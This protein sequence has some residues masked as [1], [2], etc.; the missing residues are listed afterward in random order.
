M[1]PASVTGN[2]RPSWVVLAILCCLGVF[3]WSCPDIFAAGPVLK[4]VSLGFNRMA[5]VDRWTPALVVIDNPGPSTT[6]EVVAYAEQ[7]RPRV[8]YRRSVAVPARATMRVQ[9]IIRPPAC[10]GISFELRQGDAILAKHTEEPWFLPDC[11]PLVLVYATGERSFG[12]PQW[13]AVS[14]GTRRIRLVNCEPEMMP[15]R[16]AGYDAVD[17]VIVGGMSRHDLTASQQHALLR[18]L[19][20]GGLLILAPTDDVS[21][22]GRSFLG[23]FAPVEIIERRMLDDLSPLTRA[24]GP[25]LPTTARVPCWEARAMGGEVLLSTGDLALVTAVREGTGSVVFVAFDLSDESLRGWTHLPDFYWHLLELRHPWTSLR[26]SELP[27]RAPELLAGMV[28]GRAI[29]HSLVGV[30]LVANVALV[31]VAWVVARRW[32]RPESGWL[33]MVVAAPLVALLVYFVAGRFSGVAEARAGVI[34]IAQ[35]RAGHSE[36]RADCFLGLITPDGANCTL[37]VKGDA[38]AFPAAA[39]RGRTVAAA[40]VEQVPVIEYV[41][42]DIK[43]LRSLHLLP[44]W[45]MPLETMRIEPQMGVVEGEAVPT[46][47]GIE[48][49]VR[50]ASPRYIRSP[51]VMCNRNAVAMP[52]LKPGEEARTLLT[53]S[54]AV[55]LP[56]RFS[57]TLIR[58]EREVRRAR[59]VQS[60]FAR[61]YEDLRDT[62]VRFF[63]WVEHPLLGATAVQGLGAAPALRSEVL[64]VVQ[65]P[66]SA[67][68]GHVLLPKGVAWAVPET[69]PVT[70]FHRGEWTSFTGDLSLV[71]SFRLPVPVRAIEPE[72]LSVFVATGGTKPD[73]N[74]KLWNIRREGWETVELR[75]GAARLPDPRNYYL[76]AT[77][78]VRLRLEARPAL[79]EDGLSLRG[80]A[81]WLED[82][83]IELEGRMP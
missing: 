40:D 54:S 10:E 55:P 79:A 41:D 28:G 49:R 45:L 39:A 66:W 23:A 61:P 32:G 3:L 25:G 37:G 44:R 7:A 82:L 46:P 83:D 62:E 69:Q 18:Y 11:D 31:I 47:R 68:K 29:P 73:L 8:L 70:A 76:A 21:W 38:T 19:R 50:N 63:G 4:T 14:S 5:R 78:T 52:D 13:E 15:D 1:R 26:G 12:L 77:G 81:P 16:W 17:G 56:G 43:S 71:V 33:V 58:S 74:L 27:Q 59:I 20:A 80:R 75:D 22:L 51:F 35:G 9:M 60:L 24:F 30:F 64:W 67:P 34:A 6:F 57:P 72:R 48:V 53:T 36:A 42:A 2:H 65:I